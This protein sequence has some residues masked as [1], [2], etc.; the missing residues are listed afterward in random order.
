MVQKTLFI[1]VIVLA[2]ALPATA[3]DS[4]GNTFRSADGFFN[5]TY[6]TTW[7]PS[8]KDFALRLTDP[9]PNNP[10]RPF[11]QVDVMYPGLP[12][13]PVGTYAGTTPAQLV[14]QFQAGLGNLYS[15]S[16]LI[17]TVQ[18]GKALALTTTS[19]ATLSGFEGDI[20][21]VAVDLG[22]N[23]VAMIYAEAP[24]GS[25]TAYQQTLVEVAGTMLYSGPPTAIVETPPVVAPPPEVTPPPIEVVP[26]TTVTPAPPLAPTTQFGQVYLYYSSGT[27]T[28]YNASHTL[29]DL[30]GFALVA[31]TGERFNWNDWGIMTRRYGVGRCVF[32][33]LLD[34]PYDPPSFC[35]RV[36]QLTYVLGNTAGRFWAWDGSFNSAAEFL[37]MRGDTLVATCT[38]AA[39][40]CSFEAPV[41]IVPYEPSWFR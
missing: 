15:F 34:Q 14:G 17:E 28:I 22:G 8:E 36:R 18:A 27:M 41:P 30:G 10:F 31:P 12:G 20:A 33:H 6:P 13:W 2:L 4:G 38:V 37:V 7:T 21:L 16:A 35:S 26:D 9:N 23:H 39:G 19:G 11:I 32:L 3:Q 5:F 25:M 24:L 29:V 40:Q 1:C